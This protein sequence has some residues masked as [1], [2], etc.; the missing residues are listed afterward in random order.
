MFEKY[1]DNVFLKNIFILFSANGVAQI[2]PILATLLLARMFNKEDFGNLSV[3]MAITGVTASIASFRF[4]LAIILPKKINEA[5]NLFV[6]SFI[7]IFIICAVLC[8]LIISVPNEVFKSVLKIENTSYLKYIPISVFFVASINVFNYWY[9][10]IQNFKTLGKIKIVQSFSI[11]G[12]KLGLGFLSINFGLIYGSVFGLVVPFVL[13]ISSCNSFL[14]GI[15]KTVNVRKIKLMF[16]TYINFLKFST[17]STLFNSFSNIGL[18]ILITA[19]FGV[20]KAGIYFFCNSLV[21]LPIIVLTGSIAQVYQSS[22]AKMFHSSRDKLY[23]FT[24]H[25]QKMIGLFLIPIIL[26][27]SV[28]GG[29]IF[30][31]FFG[32][33]WVESGDLIKYIAV[34]I[35]FNNLY[36][37]ISSI[38]D[39]LGEQKIILVFNICLTF[40]QVFLLWLFNSSPFKHVLLIISIVGALF[41]LIL[42][43]YMK[44]K[45]KKI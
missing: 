19:F 23:K 12:L 24:L 13:Y 32:S 1:R 25:I 7:G 29:S 22:A 5:K 34:F 21:R 40:S 14:K 33:D 4:E 17:I 27:L 26:V 20:E 45:I 42:D 36:S 8:L 30:G 38:A 44:F 10:R 16:F 9:I 18:P 39:V 6:L 15:L 3:F 43:F 37:P 31:L 28:F 41:F 11:A 35:L 2:L